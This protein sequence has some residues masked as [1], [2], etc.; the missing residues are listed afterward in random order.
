MKWLLKASFIYTI[1]IF[2]INLIIKFYNKNLDKI[3]KNVTLSNLIS[4][5][6]IIKL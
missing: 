2:L 6:I 3:L 5:I 4:A 1:A